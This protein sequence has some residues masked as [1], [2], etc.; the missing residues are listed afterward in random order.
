MQR[1]LELIKEEIKNKKFNSINNRIIEKKKI[2]C[3]AEITA[4]EFIAADFHSNDEQKKLVTLTN[5]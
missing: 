5:V 1:L 4:T 2:L 3:S